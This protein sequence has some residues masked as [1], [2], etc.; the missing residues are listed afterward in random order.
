[1]AFNAAWEVFYPASV[2]VENLDSKECREPEIADWCPAFHEMRAELVLCHPRY[3]S[4]AL[5]G[6]LPEFCGK[7]IALDIQAVGFCDFVADP[8]AI[9]YVRRL[10]P[11]RPVVDRIERQNG[12]RQHLPVVCRYWIV[13][14]SCNSS[15]VIVEHATESLPF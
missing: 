3:Q 15:I 12:I 2:S 6:G 4:E 13:P 11:L 5:V 14:N 10:A 8:G 7:P 1:M 9:Q